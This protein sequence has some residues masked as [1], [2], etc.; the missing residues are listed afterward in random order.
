[1]DAL[2]VPVTEPSKTVVFKRLAVRTLVPSTQ[3]AI[4]IRLNSATVEINESTI[5]QT[6]QA[7]LLAQKPDESPPLGR[8]RICSALQ[9]LENVSF[10]WPRDMAEA[11]FTTWQQFRWLM[12]WLQVE[13]KQT[14][15]P[16]NC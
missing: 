15:H 12:E 13:Q 8:R 16:A 5:Q 9:A 1:M 3:V 6:I 7:V 11:K 10:K 2:P 14:I 4:I